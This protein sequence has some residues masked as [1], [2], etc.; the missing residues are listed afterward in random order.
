MSTLKIIKL[1]EAATD[2]ASTLRNYHLFA[3]L[4]WQDVATRYRRS[5]VGAFWLTINMLVMISVIGVVFGSIFGLKLAE[6]L[7]GLA[8]GL[9]VWG[10]V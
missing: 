7:P 9:I 3:T 6:F 4:G 2:V 1:N 8:I 10:L 5:R